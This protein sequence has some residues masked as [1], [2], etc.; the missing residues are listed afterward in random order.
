[1]LKAPKVIIEQHE[2]YTK[3]TYRNRCNIISANGL[4]PLSIPIDKGEE[5]KCP[6]KEIR[7]SEHGNWQALHWKS[8]VSAYN[9]SPFFE[10]YYD[11][12]VHFYDR[13]FRY[14]FD[15]NWSLMELILNQ[16]DVKL[17]L[18]FSSSFVSPQSQGLLDFRESIHPKKN[19][20]NVDEY[21]NEIGYYQVFEHKF[22]FIPNCSIVDLLFNMGPESE[23]V[24]RK[25][26]PG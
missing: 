19:P 16:L 15:F 13:K 17:D 25:M 22:G 5:L 20:A 24:L 2:N 6:I 3:Q 26:I 4:I 8:I 12:F 23:S 9:S 1:M 18:S 7:M 14:L 21:Y 10:Y 11:D